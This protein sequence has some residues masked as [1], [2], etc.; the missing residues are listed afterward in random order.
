M[1]T[2]KVAAKVAA[3]VVVKVVVETAVQATQKARAI[4]AALARVIVRV[5]AAKRL[6]RSRLRKAEDSPKGST[7]M[8]SWPWHKL[9]LQTPLSSSLP[10]CMSK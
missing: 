8:R 6:P 5:K 4:A 10:K 1:H 9:N 3:E 7:R 2:V